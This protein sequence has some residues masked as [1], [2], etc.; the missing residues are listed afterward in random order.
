MTETRANR[1][2]RLLAWGGVAGLVLAT[3]AVRVS[4]HLP[5]GITAA[6]GDRLTIDSATIDAHRPARSP[7][8]EEAILSGKQKQ[9]PAG[10]G[11]SSA[12]VPLTSQRDWKSIDDPEQDGWGI[13][14]WAERA[15]ERLYHAARVVHGDEPAD[16]SALPRL[17]TEGFVG[18]RLAPSEGI[19]CFD[20]SP[21]R[22]T[23]WRASA[24]AVPE[25][26]HRGVEGLRDLIRETSAVW[27]SAV[28]RRFEVKVYR[29]LQRE[30]VLETRQY[31]VV[32]GRIGETYLEQHAN[33]QTEWQVDEGLSGLRLRS[34]RLLEFEQTERRQPNPLFSDVTASVM[35][36]DRAFHDQLMFG[37]NHWLQRT[38]DMRYFAPL[39]TPGLAVGDVDNNGFEDLYLCQ[40]ADLPNLLFLHQPDGTAIEAGQAWGVD[41]LE[42]SRGCLL[43]DLD[44]DGDQDLVVAV[45]GGVVV[46][47]NEG[48]AFR[49]RDVLPTDDDTTSLSA[50]D[51]DL[52]GD[53]DLYVCVDYPNDFFGTSRP[54][55]ELGAGEPDTTVQGGAANRVYHDAN[56]AGRNSFFLNEWSEQRPWHFTDAT[57]QLG[58]DEDNRRFS[59]A[60][61][62]DDYDND[63]DPDLYVANDFGRNCLYRNDGGEF[64]NVAPQVG[65]EDSAAGMSAAWSD[66][67]HD[68]YMDLY[69]SNMFSSAGSRITEQPKFKRDTSDE[70]KRR[71]RRFALGNTLF[72]SLRGEAFHDVSRDAG[73]S[74]GR[75]SWSSN[76]VD[77]N[78]DSWR[79]LVVANGYITTD[80]TSD[81]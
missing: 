19:V 32:N 18:T 11:D 61:C 17:I 9:P 26:C 39:G 73:V 51:I 1:R 62:W 14:V 64:K 29:T 79:D 5:R 71:W 60:A 55:R 15:K 67:D 40:E 59:W 3:L 22:V 76:F 45:L 34:I 72:H 80:D 24:N 54:L 2:W 52:D 46:A 31:V 41:F 77:V 8:G 7:Q 53:L 4:W 69:V 70:L 16:V 48:E 75:W 6:T 23:R 10:S 42:G 38:Q 35:G 50:T 13:E 56:N 43:V 74:L 20:D 49:I 81:L 36:G 27:A 28:D 57:D 44:N 30:D 33:W 58:L 47:S 12:V 65:V 68:G 25:F 21:L 78:N 37:L 66:V 63:G